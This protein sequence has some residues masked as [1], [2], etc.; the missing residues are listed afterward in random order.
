M[1][2]ATESEVPL[3][4]GRASPARHRPS[5]GLLRPKLGSTVP[6]L[7][8][9]IR[10]ASQTSASDPSGVAPRL[11]SQTMRHATGHPRSRAR[12]VL[13]VVR[14]LQ[15][16]TAPTRASTKNDGKCSSETPRNAQELTHS[17]KS[18]WKCTKP[19][20]RPLNSPIVSWGT[21][22]VLMKGYTT[23]CSSSTCW[24]LKALTKPRL[25]ALLHLYALYGMR[26]PRCETRSVCRPD[27]GRAPTR[28]CTRSSACH[29]NSWTSCA[30]QRRAST[31]RC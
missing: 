3:V 7:G 18:P 28:R 5:A 13:Q 6:Q 1:P 29:W 15:A 21:H 12:V 2:R 25:T 27:R 31:P 11:T 22:D 24:T 26:R 14:D 30:G 23:M 4:A 10:Q 16:S 20:R 17:R 19:K 9:F 8:R